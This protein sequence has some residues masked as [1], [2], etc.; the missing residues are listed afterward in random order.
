[1]PRYAREYTDISDE[2]IEIILAYRKSIL[3]DSRRIS[4]KSHV[5]NFDVP[6]GAYDSAQVDN[7]IEIYILD[8]LDS[9]VNLEQVGL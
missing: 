6:M 1:M 5:D 7:L 2:E 3:T 4:V 9:I 8:T